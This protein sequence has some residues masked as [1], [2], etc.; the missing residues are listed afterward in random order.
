MT[1]NASELVEAMLVTGSRRKLLLYLFGSLV[2]V[3]GGIFMVQDPSADAGWA[4]SSLAFFGLCALVFICLLVRPQFLLLDGE[5]F[6]VGGGLV[7]SPKKIL[8]RDVQGFFVYKPSRR[9][10]MIGF[11]FEPGVRKHTP[12]DRFAATFGAEGALPSGW[13]GRPEKM[14]EKLNAY[15]QRA[16]AQA[17]SRM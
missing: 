6:T 9:V 8:W 7:W 16:I 17:C 2:F 3:L 15:R 14:V 10:M 11:N 5:G 1:G 13:P 12:L 4:W